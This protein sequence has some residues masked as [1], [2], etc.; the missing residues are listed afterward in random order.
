MIWKS[1]AKKIL[2]LEFAY[3]FQSQASGDGQNN[4]QLKFCWLRFTYHVRIKVVK[5]CLGQFTS[6]L[7]ENKLQQYFDF[8]I[9]TVF[10]K[11]HHVNF[12]N[13]KVGINQILYILTIN[14]IDL[15][16]FKLWTLKQTIEDNYKLLD[17]LQ[18]SFL[19][20]DAKSE[21]LPT[22]VPSTTTS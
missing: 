7:V 22:P 18:D 16:D 6:T 8:E 13:P 19:T 3:D 2:K 1:W 12:N 11:S 21:Q 20:L 5:Q 15:F 14:Q 10:S 4:L 9:F 17:T